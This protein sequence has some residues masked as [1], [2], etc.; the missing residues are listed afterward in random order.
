[1]AVLVEELVCGLVSSK[2]R[3]A[4]VLSGPGGTKMSKIGM[5]PLV[6]GTSAVNCL[7][8]SVELMC[9]MNCCLCSVF[10]MKK[11]SSTY[12]SHNLVG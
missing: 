11:V 10:W 3:L 8:G 6:L 5:D 12:L 4:V 2:Q 9:Y 1:M 7:C